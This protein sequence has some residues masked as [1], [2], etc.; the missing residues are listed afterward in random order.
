VRG[1]RGE[2]KK[3]GRRGGGECIKARD[4]GAGGEKRGKGGKE[5]GQGGGRVGKG[6]G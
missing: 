2:G 3:R 4:R 1:V 5:V 6:R